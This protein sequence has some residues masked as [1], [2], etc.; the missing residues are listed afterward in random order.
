MFTTASRHLQNQA[1]RFIT[2]RQGLL[3]SITSTT[4]HG[5]AAAKS[6][7]KALQYL[8]LFGVAS[9][10]TY[11]IQQ[12]RI[13]GENVTK[14]AAALGRGAEVVSMGTPTQ[15]SSTGIMFPNL[16]NAMTFVGCGVRIKY[17]FIKVRDT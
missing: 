12:S 2:A 16:C 6:Q 11:S 17:G 8:L 14:C 5:G 9:A 4:Q 7:Q 1:K 10:T 3:R 15:E 13:L